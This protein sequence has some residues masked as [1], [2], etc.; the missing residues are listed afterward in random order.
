MVRSPVAEMFAVA[1]LAASVGVCSRYALAPDLQVSVLYANKSSH[2][3]TGQP[4]TAIITWLTPGTATQVQPLAVPCP[5]N[6]NCQFTWYRP[7][8]RTDTVYPHE[9]TCVHFTAPSDKVA[10]EFTETWGGT[11]GVSVAG[12]PNITWHTESA[13]GFDGTNVLPVGD[14]LDLGRGVMPGC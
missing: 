9:S 7:G 5:P 4:G 8:F 12:N 3:G 2:V 6:G 11:S 1:S 10:A 14:S 13:W